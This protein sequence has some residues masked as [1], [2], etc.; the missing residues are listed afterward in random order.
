[1]RTL[2]EALDQF[3]YH[4]ATPET[5]P[6]HAAIR[7]AFAAFVSELWDL[8]PPGPER[9]LVFRELQRS[10]M[11]ANLAVA[12]TVPADLSETR[13]VARVLPGAGES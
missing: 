12:L 2:E 8:V 10:Q 9:T 3:A 13:D 6:K 1:V 5:A 4:P 11:F 7:D